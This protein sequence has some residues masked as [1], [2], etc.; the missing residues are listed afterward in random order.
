LGMLAARRCGMPKNAIRLH[1]EAL[2]FMKYTIKTVYGI[3]ETNYTST[4]FEP[5]FGSGQGS[6]ASPAVWLTLVVLLLHTLDRLVPDRM[7]FESISG[8]RTHSRTADAFVDDTSV[9]F[10]S[11]ADDEPYENIINRLQKIAQTWE[12]LLHLSGGKLNLNKCSWYI[13]KWDWNKGRPTL[14]KALPSD[15]PLT[16]C[17][18]NNINPVPIPMNTPDKSSKMLGVHLN[19]LGDFTDHLRTLQ[20]KADEYALRLLSP[21]ITST[22]AQIFHRTIYTPSMRYSLAALALDEETLSTVQTR[23]L[24]SMLQTMHFSSKIPTS[25]R[26]GPLELGGIG[27][28]D[29]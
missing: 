26:H 23:V 6:G 14:R 22:D 28:Y 8:T 18:G 5:L 2:Q 12:H 1:S 20:V 11:S 16:L 9:G 19:P 3:S 21:R 7:H 27:L 4:P 10:T 25:V 29:L 17:Q 13:L 15:P 24:Q